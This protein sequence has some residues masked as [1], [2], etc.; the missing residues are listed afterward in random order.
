MLRALDTNHWERIYLKCRRIQASPP[1]RKTAEQAGWQIGLSTSQCSYNSAMLSRNQMAFATVGEPSP[2]SVARQTVTLASPADARCH[3][4]HECQSGLELS[5]AQT[6][7]EMPSPLKKS[8]G[9]YVPHHVPSRSRLALGID[10]K[11]IQATGRQSDIRRR[12]IAIWPHR[13]EG[14]ALCAR[15]RRRLSIVAEGAAG[16]KLA[17]LPNN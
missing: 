4:S 9:E 16:K 14:I 6:V 13:R 10:A 12:S 17:T 2:H 8:T 11:D 3:C 1:L 7:G 5:D 15:R